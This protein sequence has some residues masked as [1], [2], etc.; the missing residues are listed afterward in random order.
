MTLGA[1]ASSDNLLSLSLRYISNMCNTF[2][3]SRN[4]RIYANN[5]HGI[6]FV[7]QRILVFI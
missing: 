5:F 1:N 3:L 2:P 7:E 4:F 6:N